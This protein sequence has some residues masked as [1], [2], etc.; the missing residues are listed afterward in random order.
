M[1]TKSIQKTFCNYFSFGI[2]GKIGYSFDLHRAKSRLGNLVVYACMGVI[3]A[4]T[5]TKT[6]D[7]LL[8]S[9][10]IYTSQKKKIPNGQQKSTIKKVE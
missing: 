10:Q 6:L 4:A 9:I 2:D 7:E 5:R 3:K 8:E 1:E